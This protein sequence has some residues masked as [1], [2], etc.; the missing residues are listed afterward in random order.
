[1]LIIFFLQRRQGETAR[2]PLDWAERSML[3]FVVVMLMSLIIHG[4]YASADGE[5]NLSKVMQGYAIPTVAYCIARRGVR[6][7]KQLHT[8]FVGLGFIALYLAGTGVAE[9]WTIR[10]LVFPQFILNPEVGIHFGFA[11]A[12]GIFLNASYLG[13]A[14]AM[15]LPFLIWLYF[16]DRAPR[17]WLWPV[18]AALAA[19]SLVFSFQRAAWLS[20]IAAL[21]VTVVS[22]TQRRIALTAFLV[23]A[24]AWGV[25][26]VPDTFIQKLE[27]R[28]SDKGTID[29]RLALIE[30]GWAMFQANPVLGVGLNRYGA[31]I[32]QF[33]SK[34]SP[35]ISH[36]TWITLLAELGLVG[37]LSYL[38]IFACVL[39]E[40][41]KFYVQYPQ[42]RAFLG[43][44]GGVTLAFVAMSISIEM[45]GF[46]YANT[47]LFA[48]WGMILE[49][50]R[51]RTAAGQAL[52]FRTGA[53]QGVT[54]QVATAHARVGEHPAFDRL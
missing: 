45:R 24:A 4:S 48:L 12:R 8:F 49:A 19:L 40:A 9:T 42:Y 43:M 14:I 36:N 44:L 35:R 31:E 21:G 22:W 1:V 10:W 11:G 20:A 54:S 26:F 47:F 50:V 46:L 52:R 51:R 41:S 29:Y 3:A 16:T 5:W 2:L 17:R 18:V 32:E 23:F 38:A 25:F 33:S 6:T 39:G 13:L 34:S 7:A 53:R 27:V 37:T 30:R 28:L 15:L